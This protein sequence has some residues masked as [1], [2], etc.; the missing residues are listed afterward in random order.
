MPLDGSES[1]KLRLRECGEVLLPVLRGRGWRGQQPLGGGGGGAEVE[2]G[3]GRPR[4]LHRHRAGRG[5]AGGRRA[6]PHVKPAAVSIR[7][8]NK[9]SRSLKFHNHEE[10]PY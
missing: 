6:R 2:H 5:L 7:T 10:G 8:G 4:P 1:S 3:G 9:P